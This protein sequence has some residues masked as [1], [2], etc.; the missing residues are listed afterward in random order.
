M[1]GLAHPH[2]YILLKLKALQREASMA[3]YSVPIQLLHPLYIVIGYAVYEIVVRVYAC[4]VWLFIHQ[5]AE[6]VLPSAHFQSLHH[7]RASQF[8]I[9]F[10]GKQ[11]DV[12]IVLHLH[13]TFSTQ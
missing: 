11:S 1:A 10:F 13:R 7:N 6:A 5:E 4:V 8:V 12:D 2:I 3:W 9:A